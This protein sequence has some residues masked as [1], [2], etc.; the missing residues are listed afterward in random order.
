[1]LGGHM[2]AATVVTKIQVTQ[3]GLDEILKEL[4]ELEEIKL[5]A[6]IKRVEAA[7]AYGD[8]SENSE[9]HSAKEDQQLIETR[10]SELKDVVDRA[11]VV[12][13]TT[14]HTAVGMGSQVVV[15]VKSSKS[16]RKLTFHIVGEFE[17]DPQNGKVSSVSPL[18]KAL[19]GKKKDDEV[20]VKA[21]AGKITY[22]IAEI[23]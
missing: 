2:A 22:Q 4:K 21:P 18:G 12:K 1:M 19:M 6:N 15:A 8:L 3:E 7:R 11:V 13:H 17:A 5:P 16:K 20:E 23:K 9:Y 10:L 14:K